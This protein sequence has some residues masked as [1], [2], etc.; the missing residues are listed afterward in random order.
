MKNFE[1]PHDALVQVAK[2][3]N[4]SASEL[5]RSVSR[6]TLPETT[7]FANLDAIHGAAQV[8]CFV[9]TS[10]KELAIS[11]HFEAHATVD[12]DATL[13]VKKRRRNTEAEER[14]ERVNEARKQLSKNMPDLPS[15]ELDVA[16]IALVRLVNKLRGSEG[17]V[18][19]QSYALLGK[20]LAQTDPRPRVV[21][22]VRLH[23]GIAMPVDLLKEV[24]GTCW[25]DG[26]LTTLATLHGISEVDLP[27]SAEAKAALAF[28]NTPL[29][30]VT[31]VP[32]R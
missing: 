31:S 23:A 26:L 27:Y 19:V 16:E 25:K 17:E 10:G 13:P 7:S 15:A 1:E 9:G 6:H 8:P 18:C 21:M 5:L 32:L 2:A 11:A 28:G 20:K 30:L 4:C 12:N 22:A 3:Q 14:A 24:L 29:L